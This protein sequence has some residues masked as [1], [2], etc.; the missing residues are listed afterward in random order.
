MDDLQARLR[1]KTI[2]NH[3]LESQVGELNIR[4]SHHLEDLAQAQ[5]ER[6]RLD[7]KCKDAEDK[8]A[9]VSEELKESQ[10]KYEVLKLSAAL[11]V[12]LICVSADEDA[13]YG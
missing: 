5:T 10:T 8:L 7:A 4:I 1:E 3:R 12:R 2:E 11:Q 13:T 6:D 9:A